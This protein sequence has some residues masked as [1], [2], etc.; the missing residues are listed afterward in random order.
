MDTRTP[1]A[2]GQRRHPG[3]FSLGDRVSYRDAC[4]TVIADLATK[5]FAPTVSIRSCESL[6]AGVLVEWDDHT[7]THIRE[8][9]IVLRRTQ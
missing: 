9:S 5:Q 6:R 2:A 3:T 1:V 4:G 7:V 8:P